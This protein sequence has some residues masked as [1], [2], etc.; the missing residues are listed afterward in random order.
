MYVTSTPPK[1]KLKKLHLY[2]LVHKVHAIAKFL[3]PSWGKVD[4]GLGL[5]YRPVR[6]HRLGGRYDNPMPESTNLATGEWIFE[7]FSKVCH[8]LRWFFERDKLN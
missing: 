3:V 7:Y 4:S 6:L 1:A 2:R 5:T 8:S